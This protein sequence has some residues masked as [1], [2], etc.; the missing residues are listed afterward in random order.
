MKRVESVF[1]F[2]FAAA[3]A[4]FAQESAFDRTA[5]EGA[6][7]I[8]LAELA[9]DTLTGR[10]VDAALFA[11][12]LEDPGKYRTSAEAEALLRADYKL[13]L[14]TNYADKARQVLARLAKPH[15]TEEAFA[16]EFAAASAALDAAALDESAA[17]AYPAVYAAARTNACARQARGLVALVRPTEAEV[18][19]LDGAEL[20]KTLTERLVANQRTPVFE[21][22]VAYV[23]ERLAEPL[24]ADAENQRKRQGEIVKRAHPEGWAPEVVAGNLVRH[25]LER[26]ADDKARTKEGEWTY[27]VFP[28]VTNKT[29][30]AAVEKNVLAHVAE[31]VAGVPVTIDEELV[32]RAVGAAPDKAARNEDAAKTVRPQFE[33][34]LKAS[35][36]ADAVAEAPERER[37]AFRA[38]AA[39]RLGHGAV[40][41]AVQER[42][43]RE[44]TPVI[45]RVRA[46]YAREFKLVD[47]CGDRVAN[48]MKRLI[49]KGEPL[50]DVATLEKD[51][52]RMVAAGWESSRGATLFPGVKEDEHPIAIAEL[53]A[54]VFPPV[55][56]RIKE[57]AKA[58]LDAVKLAGHSK[59]GG[60]V[61]GRFTC[62]VELKRTDAQITA[63][64]RMEGAQIEQIALDADPAKF[65]GDIAAAAQ[66]AR[67][68]LADAL[69]K[70][71]LGPGM[72]LTVEIVADD[73]VYYGAATEFLRAVQDA[74]EKLGI[75]VERPEGAFK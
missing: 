25:L 65:R 35:A 4:A 32:I 7:R 46:A 48:E 19:A 12:M 55:K 39:A 70:K 3:A 59:G 21:E 2:F 10:G 68:L 18:D 5:A 31:S 44:L 11:K 61:M 67:G 27:G 66:K 13:E 52:A 69:A 23:S 36:L 50:P 60:G 73:L 34:E 16:A 54:D 72:I 29:L 33:D 71:N 56:A 24:I 17:S 47:D 28:S 45:E 57:K 74:A 64:F 1:F 38:Y 53:Y 14:A 43:D 41:K 40:K 8:V 58:I 75:A 15:K 51:L 30:E 20:K 37:E 26:V 9:A 22:N 63:D 62:T 42:T 49:P 6:A